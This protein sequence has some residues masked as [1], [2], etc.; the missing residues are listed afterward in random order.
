MLA[1]DIIGFHVTG[2]SYE[3]TNPAADIAVPIGLLAFWAY[4]VAWP[5]RQAGDWVI[6]EMFLALALF[7]SISAIA[8]PGQYAAVA[9]KRPLFDTWAA[10][11]DSSLGVNVSTWAAWT[12]A[13]PRL[14]KVLLYAYMSL[15]GQFFL[16]LLVLGAWYRNRERLWEFAFHFHVCSAI[17]VACLAIWPVSEPLFHYGFKPSF[18]ADH[19]VE[20]F[21]AV[22]S[23]ALTIVN[24]DNMEGLV[25]LPSFHAAGALMV[26]WA[27][28]QS[29]FWLAILIPVNA[30][31]IAATVMTGIHYV[32][33]LI[34]TAIMCALS[35]WLYR[36]FAARWIDPFPPV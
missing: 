25:S 32:A 15:L 11:V 33:D 7:T 4:F 10:A 27:L 6:A 8:P 28:R 16:P 20:Q 36:R 19:Y 9:F 17:T 13:H 23:G 3:W 31:L 21:T 22:Y 24:S 34:G 12:S 1:F 5:G 26:T 35:L 2:L 14:L 30:A 18:N 29:R